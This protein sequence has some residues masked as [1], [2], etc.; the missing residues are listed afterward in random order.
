MTRPTGVDSEPTLRRRHEKSAAVLIA[1]AQILE[2]SDT[3]DPET[4]EF[5]Q[6]FQWVTA[7]TPEV[8]QEVWQDPS[9]Y[10]W[11][12]VTYE[13]MMAEAG[14][15]P[16]SEL[17]AGYRDAADPGNL[18]GVL[19]SSLAEIRLFAS[20]CG[21]ISNEHIL[22]SHPLRLELP[23]VLPGTGYSLQ[24]RGHILLHGFVAGALRVS[25]PGRDA[26]DLLPGQSLG[27]VTWQQDPEVALEGAR[28]R[29]QP[30]L[31]NLP[32]MEPQIRSVAYLDDNSQQAANETLKEALV[33]IERY[34]PDTFAA[35][36]E[37][38]IVIAIKN[39]RE[40]DFSNISHSILPGAFVLTFVPNGPELADSII[41]EFHHGLLF[42]R[43]ED[44]AF[45]E[46]QPYHP[47]TDYR[48]Y[49]PWRDEPRPLHGLLHA[50]YVFGPVARYWLAMHRDSSLTADLRTYALSQLHAI[51]L[52]R[53]LVIDEL[54]RHAVFTPSGRALFEQQ[55]TNALALHR[56]AAGI[57]RYG[58]V[59]ALVCLA[60]GRIETR[61]DHASQKP[62]SVR[63]WLRQHALAHGAS[64]AIATLERVAA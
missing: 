53:L 58:D 55:R 6:I 47:H 13:L 31:F 28:L 50:L 51:T 36:R 42:A 54:E 32:S 24:G 7:I 14:A 1:I 39:A 41:H 59:P 34:A 61:R 3:P 43:E 56:S 45:M 64:E 15:V 62:L 12:T 52:R 4:S 22:F 11:A 21:W 48:F 30:A 26:Q 46:P 63:E 29:L 16:L 40:T 9:T 49:S 38:P 2:E 35:L 33:L 57:A 8:F 23:R 44:G 10:H 19:R 18:A 27:F 25:Q 5:L 20:A 37:Q 17:A 60:D